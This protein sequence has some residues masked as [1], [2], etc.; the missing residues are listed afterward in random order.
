MSTTSCL[1]QNSKNT[2][3]PTVH[4]NICNMVG[5][6][7]E[8]SGNF[9]SHHIL[10]NIIWWS[11]SICLVLSWKIGLYAMQIATWLSWYIGIDSEFQLLKQ[12]LHPCHLGSSMSHI[13]IL[14]HGSHIPRVL[15]SRRSSSGY[16]CSYFTMLVIFH[17]SKYNIRSGPSLRLETSIVYISITFNL[18]MII[19]HKWQPLL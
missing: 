12:S 13:L 5:R 11:T 10:A 1:L 4:K 14:L 18:E 17:Q 9:L 16:T 19:F 8:W 15:H 6:R 7:S 2:S 3:H